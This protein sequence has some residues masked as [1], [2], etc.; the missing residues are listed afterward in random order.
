M[1]TFTGIIMLISVFIG[2]VIFFAAESAAQ[3]VVALVPIVASYVFGRAL[4]NF[5]EYNS[6]KKESE[7]KFEDATTSDYDH[8][9]VETKEGNRKIISRL[10]WAGIIESNRKDDYTAIKYYKSKE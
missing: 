10:E 7:T 5:T 6:N 1:R 8:I 9:Q 2:T 3:E 4:E